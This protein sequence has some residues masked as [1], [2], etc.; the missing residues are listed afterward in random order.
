MLTNNLQ[1]YNK[2]STFAA[3]LRHLR[4]IQEVIFVNDFD[5]RAANCP[6]RVLLYY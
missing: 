3:C 2:S 1:F 6:N 4:K 5:H